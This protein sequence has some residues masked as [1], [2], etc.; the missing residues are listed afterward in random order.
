MDRATYIQLDN[1]E[2]KLDNL[3]AG[4][5]QIIERDTI[6]SAIGLIEAEIHEREGKLRHLKEDKKVLAFLEELQNSIENSED[7][8]IY[9]EEGKENSGMSESKINID[10][11]INEIHNKP[12]GIKGIHQ[13]EYRQ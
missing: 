4:I 11:D 9:V 12:R 10:N 5:S 2:R 8:E 1:M 7:E 6:I 3:T 13:D